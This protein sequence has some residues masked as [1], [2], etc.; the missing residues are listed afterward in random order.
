MTDES[1]KPCGEYHPLPCGLDV[2]CPVDAEYHDSEATNA[3]I[4]ER[5]EQSGTNSETGP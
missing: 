5:S 1:E 3:E 2:S 4:V